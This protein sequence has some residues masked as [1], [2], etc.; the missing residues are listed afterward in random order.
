MTGKKNVE[1]DEFFG[2]EWKVQKEFVEAE[3]KNDG[4]DSASRHH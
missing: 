1:E 3:Y 4:F 2:V